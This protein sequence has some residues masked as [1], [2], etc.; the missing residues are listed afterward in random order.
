[1]VTTAFAIS[2]SLETY[3][4]S[5][6]TGEDD[7]GRR[8]TRRHQQL[9]ERSATGSAVATA[10]TVPC[11]RNE[12]DLTRGLGHGRFWRGFDPPLTLTCNPSKNYA[13]FDVLKALVPPSDEDTRAQ[14]VPPAPAAPEAGLVG[15]GGWNHAV[16]DGGGD[17]EPSRGLF[18][19]R[20]KQSR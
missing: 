3:C 9:R 6:R 12:A 7:A 14:P 4:S 5:S 2:T 11:T 19:L 17:S 8:G 16:R 20:L 18:L 13:A 15:S 10:A 1:M